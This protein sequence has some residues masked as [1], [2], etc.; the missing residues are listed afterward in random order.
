MCTSGLN[1]R[2]SMSNP[3]LIYCTT[4]AAGSFS[5]QTS[6]VSKPTT[7]ARCNLSKLRN[8][9]HPSPPQTNSRAHHHENLDMSSF[10]NHCEHRL[11]PASDHRC[12]APLT[13]AQP[14]LNPFESQHRQIFWVIV[15]CSI[16]LFVLEKLKSSSHIRRAHERIELVGQDPKLDEDGQ[17]VG[18]FFFLIYIY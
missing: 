14:P 1:L 18:R 15:S 12:R 16:F 11:T 7:L 10:F 17:L 13:T 8:S 2:G 3:S 9:G 6:N 4:A 5:S